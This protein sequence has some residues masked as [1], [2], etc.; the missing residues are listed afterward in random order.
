MVG[1][2]AH[3]AGVCGQVVDTIGVG[4][5]QFTDEVVNLDLVQVPG[6]PPFLPVVFVVADE[7]FFLGVDGNNRITGLAGLT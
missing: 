7:F 6:G 4:L 5:A 2:H 1:T 3:P